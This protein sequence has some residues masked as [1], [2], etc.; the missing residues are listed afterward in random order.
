[1]IIGKKISNHLIKWDSDG[2]P[3]DEKLKK[4]TKLRGL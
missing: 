2:L 1:M 3:K 4:K